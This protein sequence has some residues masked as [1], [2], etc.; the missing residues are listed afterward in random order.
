MKSFKSFRKILGGVLVLSLLLMSFG[1]ALASGKSYYVSVN[2]LYVRSGPGSGYSKV[3]TLKR[4]AVVTKYDHSGG[5]WKVKF[6]GGTGYV[7]KTYLSTVK[8]SSGSYKTTTSVRMRAKANTSSSVVK[9]LKKGAKVSL[10]RQSG[11]WAYVSYGGT[12]GW[13]STKYLKRS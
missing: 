9:H 11:S 3:A 10:I 12:K 1:S 6:S 5:W 13:V 4:G 2:K 7:Y 8:N